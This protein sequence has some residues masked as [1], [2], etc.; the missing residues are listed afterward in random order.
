MWH[1]SGTTTV[2]KSHWLQIGKKNR[3]PREAFCPGLY[4]PDPVSPALPHSA[5]PPNGTQWVT[6][7]SDATE[8]AESRPRGLADAQ[9]GEGWRA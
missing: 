6:Q 2:P 7:P 3:V 4:A 8:M 9:E 5:V 1:M